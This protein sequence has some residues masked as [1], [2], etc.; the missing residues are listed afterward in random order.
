[1]FGPGVSTMPNETRAK[2][3]SEERWGMGRL[4]SGVVLYTAHEITTPF[5]KWPDCWSNVS[6]GQSCPHCP[7]KPGDDGR[8]SGRSS[9]F[10]ERPD[11]ARINVQ[12]AAE[13][14]SQLGIRRNAVGVVHGPE[15]RQ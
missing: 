15:Q 4:V 9:V 7:V 1:M 10:F 14:N 6:G 12:R 5:R 3:S 2:P 11:R 13:R 8:L